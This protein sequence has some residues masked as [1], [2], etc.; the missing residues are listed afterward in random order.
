MGRVFN[1]GGLEPLLS[2][3]HTASAWQRFAA[4]PCVFL[5]RVLYDYS[6]SSSC[7][8]SVR[9]APTRL[10]LQKP[11]QQQQQQARITVVCISDTHNSQPDVPDGDVLIHAG[12]LTQSGTLVEIERAVGWLR[13]LPHRYKIV[14]AGNHDLLL[15]PSFHSARGGGGG[16]GGSTG[17]GR[18]RGRQEEDEADRPRA[19]RERIDWTGLVYLNDEATT[20]QFTSSGSGTRQLS[21]YGSPL[22]PR[23]GNWAFQ[24]PRCQAEDIWRDRI[25]AGTDILVTHGPPKAHLD[26]TAGLGCDSLLREVWRKRSRLRLHVFGHI[27]A[28]YGPD[29]LRFDQVQREYE[30]TVAAHGG[31]ANLVRM[32]WAYMLCLVARIFYITPT[33]KGESSSIT[34]VRALAVNAAHTG[35]LWDEKR[36]KAIIVEI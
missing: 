5:A 33:T 35:G 18:E 36:R 17:I 11:Q 6:C 29:W 26:S 3:P 13:G 31:L 21:I 14:V 12:D 9:M 24:Y 22:T 23:H 32:L 10:P 1:G 30:K 19:S 7:S 16:G 20:L 28:G 4:Q 27:H 34:G 2:R 25:P 8:S 15:D